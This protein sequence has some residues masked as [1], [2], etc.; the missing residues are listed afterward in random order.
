MFQS[1]HCSHSMLGVQRSRDRSKTVST[2][3]FLVRIKYESLLLKIRVPIYTTSINKLLVSKYCFLLYISNLLWLAKKKK[4]LWGYPIC[5]LQHYCH[6]SAPETSYDIYIYHHDSGLRPTRQLDP[7]S[8]GQVSNW[9]LMFYLSQIGHRC[10]N[11]FSNW[12]QK[13]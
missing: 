7:L 4:L 13:Y 9:F 1:S 5:I 3:V 12:S 6:L 10:F 11:N 2:K 8:M